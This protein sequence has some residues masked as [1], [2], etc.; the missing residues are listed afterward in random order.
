MPTA[1]ALSARCLLPLSASDFPP[2]SR[3]LFALLR[4]PSPAAGFH[5][6]P[7]SRAQHRARWSSH[8]DKDISFRW[9]VGAGPVL[10]YWFQCRRRSEVRTRKLQAQCS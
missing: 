4:N 9:D 1:T 3:R 2:E 5:R 8:T 6:G 10:V 7:P